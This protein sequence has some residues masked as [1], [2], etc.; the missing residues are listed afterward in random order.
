[1]VVFQEG[2]SVK[3]LT[4]LSLFLFALAL[5]LLPSTGGGK[6]DVSKPVVADG[7]PL[8]PPIPPAPT[9]TLMADGHY[10]RRF[11]HL[12]AQWFLT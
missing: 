3:R 1:M 5:I 7:W 6:Y 10:H 8:P 4:I 9:E 2:S 11:H 12:R